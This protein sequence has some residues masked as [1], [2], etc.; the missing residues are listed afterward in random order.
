VGLPLIGVRMGWGN[1]RLEA[2]EEL[3]E[4]AICFWWFRRFGRWCRKTAVLASVSSA[5]MDNAVLRG[6][7][8]DWGSGERRRLA[9][10]GWFT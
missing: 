8:V 6:T 7:V 4:E 5:A 9:H 1:V 2:A 10:S 3:G